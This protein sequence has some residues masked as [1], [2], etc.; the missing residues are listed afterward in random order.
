MANFQSAT[1]T[2]GCNGRVKYLEH[3]QLCMTVRHP[4]RGVI[5]VDLRSPKS[6]YIARDG[7]TRSAIVPACSQAPRAK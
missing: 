6:A 1:I 3:V 4:W 7:V 2:N 5:E